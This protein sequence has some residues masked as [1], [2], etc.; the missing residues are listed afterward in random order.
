[1]RNALFPFAVAAMLATGSNADDKKTLV[2]M[3]VTH[4][5]HVNER[6]SY[7]TTPE[8]SNTACTGTG[9]GTGTVTGDDI[10]IRT[11]TNTDCTTTTTPAKTSSVT[12]R[13]TD[14]SEEVIDSDNMVYTIACTDRPNILA[15]ALVGAAAGG[16]AGGDSTLAGSGKCKPLIDGAHF[17]AE[18]KGTTMW[19]H[20][21]KEGRK[22][23]KIKYKILNIRHYI[24]TQTPPPNISNDVRK[25]TVPATASNDECK[26]DERDTSE[27]W[28][29]GRS[30]GE[31]DNEI[32][33][34]IAAH[35]VCK[36]L[37]YL[38]GEVRPR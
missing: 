32:A 18:I 36:T 9:T 30:L 22:V 21:R 11:R 15:A 14:V 13:T 26:G 34:A 10:D 27:V 28:R 23:I 19:V 4:D 3:A 20:A 2:V 37:L 31:R 25:Q 7:H 8:E 6:T 17:G 35:G 24:P 5:S 33:D 1:M 16:G 38:R 29:L 12:T